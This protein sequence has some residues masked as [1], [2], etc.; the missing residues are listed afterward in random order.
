MS[1]SCFEKI[2]YHVAFYTHFMLFI[3]MRL[4]LKYSVNL[5]LL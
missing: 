5:M 2:I 1:I 3:F 4:F